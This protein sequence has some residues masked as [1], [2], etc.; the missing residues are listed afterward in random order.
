MPG[1]KAATEKHWS[2]PCSMLTPPRMPWWAF[3]TTIN[4]NKE[5]TQPCAEREGPLAQSRVFNK[6]AVIVDATW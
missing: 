2:L 6:V 5:Q 3:L 4:D 1:I